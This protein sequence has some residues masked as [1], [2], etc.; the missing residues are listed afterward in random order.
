ME[1]KPYIV[2]VKMD[3]ANRITAVNSSEF[4][5]DLTGW[6]EIDSGYG[7]RYHHAQGNY[8]DKPI[9]DER[10]VW[11]Y[12]LVLGV[13]QERTQEDMDADYVEPEAQ[14]TQ[15]E[16]IAALEA[17]LSAYEAAYAQGVNEA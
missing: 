10:G 6:T 1:M 12:R 9:M 15:E 5:N 3:D 17:Q 16:R 13:P 4:L 2:Y 14:P 11:R 7:D 8:F